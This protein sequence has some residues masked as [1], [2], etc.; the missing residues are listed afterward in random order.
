MIWTVEYVVNC[1]PKSI[2]LNLLFKMGLM[3]CAV[4]WVILYNT[5]QTAV[6]Q[7]WEITVMNPKFRTFGCTKKNQPP[8]RVFLA[9][10]ASQLFGVKNWVPSKKG[11]GSRVDAAAR[12][13]HHQ[14]HHAEI[15]FPSAHGSGK[16]RYAA[17]VW[18]LCGSNKTRKLQW[19]IGERFEESRADS[20]IFE[21]HIQK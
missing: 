5:M 3:K 20:G 18:E 17:G 12:E 2:E 6:V 16:P 11:D 19:R 10:F 15:Q 9:C 1:L 7:A 4:K 13:S 14:S 8:P 21:V